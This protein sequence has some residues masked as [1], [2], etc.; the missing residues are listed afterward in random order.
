MNIL[1]SIPRTPETPFK[2]YLNSLLDPIDKVSSLIRIRGIEK[3]LEKIVGEIGQKTV[4][5]ELEISESCLRGWINGRRGIPLL[6]LKTI[7][8]LQS[9]PIPQSYRWERIFISNKYFTLGGSPHQVKL[10]TFITP[11]LS[12]FVGYLYGDGYI[13]DAHQRYRDRGRML[14]EVKIADSTYE[15]INNI[16]KIL[17]NLFNIQVTIRDERISKGEQTYYIDPKCKTLHRFLNRLFEMPVGRKKG[18][19]S[20]PSLLLQASAELRKWFIAGFFDA[21]GSIF[22]KKRPSGSMYVV[23]LKQTSLEILQDIKNLLFKDLGIVLQGPYE[24]PEEAWSIS[25]G[26]YKTVKKFCKDI[27]LLHPQKVTHAKEIKS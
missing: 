15:H 12:Y 14:C 17:K 11:K 1:K 16:S 25:S 10:P 5:N 2:N 26:K 8:K 19:L 18:K 21:D 24:E 27:P 13:S 23:K 20:I 22:R 4:K 7:V 3:L 9:N 6:H